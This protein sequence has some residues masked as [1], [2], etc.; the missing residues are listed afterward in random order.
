LKIDENAQIKCVLMSGMQK[1]SCSAS[2]SNFTTNLTSDIS[3]TGG[4]CPN[5]PPCSHVYSN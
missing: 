4:K 2:E 5:W 3:L 1:K